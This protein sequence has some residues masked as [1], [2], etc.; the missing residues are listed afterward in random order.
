MKRFAAGVVALASFVMYP[1]ALLDSAGATPPAPRGTATWS[2]PPQEY[3]NLGGPDDPN[4]FVNASGAATAVWTAYDPS[5][6][7]RIFGASRQMGS[8]WSARKV[9]ANDLPDSGSLQ[10]GGSATGQ[11]VVVMWSSQGDLWALSGPDLDHLGQ[12]TRIASNLNYQ[13]FPAASLAVNS[14]GVPTIVFAADVDLPGGGTTAPHIRSVT[15]GPNGWGSPENLDINVSGEFTSLAATV[16]RRT[17]EV[18]ALWASRNST[19][20]SE[21]RG[22]YRPS[23]GRWAAYGTIA[24]PNGH[25][26]AVDVAAASSASG[27]QVAGVWQETESD[28]SGNTLEKVWGAT[29]GSI[30]GWGV[31]RQLFATPAG[32]NT[33]FPPQP[34]VQVHADG[35][36]SKVVAAWLA[37]SYTPSGVVTSRAEA[38]IASGTPGTPNS[39]A[40]S[41]NLGAAY[42]SAGVDLDMAQDGTAMV[43]YAP[44][45]DSRSTVTKTLSGATWSSAVTAIASRSGSVAN[46][47]IVVGSSNVALTAA[48]ESM[49][50]LATQDPP[51]PGPVTSLAVTRALTPAKKATISVSWARP[52]YAGSPPIAHYDVV[53]TTPWA[54]PYPPVTISNRTTGVQNS[55]Q[56]DRKVLV[57]RTWTVTVTAVNSRGDR[58]PAVSRTVT[59]P[60]LPKPK[61]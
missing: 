27:R 18:V 26:W 44:A 31:P 37:Q 6:G 35:N 56:V 20:I 43:V 14:S 40:A 1:S 32:S 21:I 52:D 25:V 49:L 60:G 12:P 33:T 10:M 51:E 39:W 9:V 16:D 58:S 4:V 7:I 50:S 3:S 11:R 48:T 46:V 22:A 28:N 47:R 57:A 19:G 61:R 42:D 41:A 13:A 53:Y 23:G 38:A 5:L 30:G 55:Q 2:T 54:G 15:L 36:Q 34:R 45:A 59:V 17:D 29:R 8:A 24:S